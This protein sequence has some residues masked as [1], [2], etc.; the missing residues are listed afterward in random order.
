MSKVILIHGIPFLLQLLDRR[1]HIHGIP[2]DHRVGHEIQTARLMRQL[3]P[4]FATQ[5]PLIGD[6]QIRAQV[7]KRLA[8]VELPQDASP[9]LIIG[10]PPQD[11][12]GSD[13]AAVLLE[14]L[15]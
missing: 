1:R 14:G 12:Q 6:H 7:V 2:Q 8:L 9:I 5:L 13:K 15:R 11:M 3:F 10:I 4:S